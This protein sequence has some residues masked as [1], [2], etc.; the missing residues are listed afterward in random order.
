MRVLILGAGAIGVSIAYHLATRGADVI[1]IERSAI[2]CAVSG[3]SGGVLGVGLVR[4]NS[5]Y[6]PCPQE[7]RVAC[8]T[9]RQAYRRMGL[10]PD[11]HLWRYRGPVINRCV[12]WSSA[13]MGFPEHL[14][15]RPARIYGHHST[16]AASGLYGRDDT[17]RGGAGSRVAAG[18]R[19]GTAAPW[20][21]RGGRRA[22]RRS[23]RGRCGCDHDR[24]LVSARSA[25][26]SSAA[27][28]RL[29][30]D[31]IIF[32]TGS[33][34]PAE[35]LFLEYAGPAGAAH[36][37]EVFPRDDGTTCVCAISNDLPL[38]VDPVSSS[39]TMCDR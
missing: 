32:E 25:M 28:V 36:S 13:R 6:A 29:E 24:A 2:A 17:R 16:G 7:L 30:R 35:A 21:R 26:A 5:S 18:Q 8:T 9:C 14:D 12:A 34:I 37:P 23:T 1:V 3:K 27:G 31:S 39:R 11:D 38:P 22:R 19:H 33:T 15:P 4:R 20:W 10:P